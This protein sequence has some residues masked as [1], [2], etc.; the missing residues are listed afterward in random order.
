[1]PKL[2]VL[3]TS[4]V[5]TGH[6]IAEAWERAGATGV[7]FIES[8]GL[9]RFNEA[10]RAFE[11]LPGMMSMLQILRE[12]DQGSLCLLSVVEDDP[13]VERLIAS[14]QSVLGDLSAPDTG[15][16]FVLDIARALGIRQRRAR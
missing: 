9:R 5:E 7:T 14:A 12:N 13:V 15:I 1:M 10:S 4:H 6:P 16:L 3:I 11:V 8:Y 2:V